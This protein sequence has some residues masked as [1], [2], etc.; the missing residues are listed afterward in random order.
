M[1]VDALGGELLWTYPI[2]KTTAVIPTPIIKGAA[3]IAKDCVAT[4]D[5]AKREVNVFV[6]TVMVHSSWLRPRAT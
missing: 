2:D 6:N 1:G 4:S 3:A 5:V